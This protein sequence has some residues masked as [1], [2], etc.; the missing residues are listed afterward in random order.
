MT[1]L[2]AIGLYYAV[3]ALWKPFYAFYRHALRPRRD[4]KT[5]YGG[6]W[7]LVTGASDGIGEQI[8]Y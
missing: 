3:K 8:C 1:G 4:L 2:A 5:R 7:A 6:N